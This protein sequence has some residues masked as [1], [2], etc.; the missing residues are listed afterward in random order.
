MGLNTTHEA[1]DGPYSQFN[2]FRR[3]LCLAAGLKVGSEF[4]EGKHYEPGSEANLLCYRGDP[5]V[6]LLGH[7]DCDGELKWQGCN[8][9]EIRLVEL[10][11]PFMEAVRK[12]EPEHEAFWARKLDRLIA[13]CRRAFNQKQDIRFE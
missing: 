1:W 2:E 8:A 9:I 11:E 13:G 6:L 5:L 12:S 10:R 7:S 3:L 4:W